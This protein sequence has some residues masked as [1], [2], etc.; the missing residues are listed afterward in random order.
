MDQTPSLEATNHFIDRDEA[1]RLI[2]AYREQQNELLNPGLL[3]EH[4]EFGILPFS[5]AFN[6][7]SILALLAQDDC[8]GIRIH[9]G[10]KYQEAN[11][12]KV[13]QIV[14]V[15]VG[16][17]KDGSNIW[18]RSAVTEP[19]RTNLKMAVTARGV[20]EDA[21]IL[22]DSQRCPPFGDSDPIP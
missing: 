8:V 6:Q 16:V 4:K 19:A 22:E 18:G 17:A 20:G 13:P 12:A 10:L 14:A 1:K 15:L 11:G 21:V 5:E 3:R 2:T 7:K 9:Y